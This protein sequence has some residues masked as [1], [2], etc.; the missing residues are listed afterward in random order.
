MQEERIMEREGQEEEARSVKRRKRR[1]IFCQKTKGWLYEKSIGEM[2]VQLCANFLSDT[3]QVNLPV[4]L[5]AKATMG[6][7]KSPLFCLSLLKSDVPSV[8]IL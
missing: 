2:R 5:F 7:I 6:I 1:I 3:G 8:G 4:S